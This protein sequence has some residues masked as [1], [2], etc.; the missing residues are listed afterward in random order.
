MKD[1]GKLLESE[2]SSERITNQANPVKGFGGI[3]PIATL[4]PWWPSQNA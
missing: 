1:L 3:N 2:T 4:R